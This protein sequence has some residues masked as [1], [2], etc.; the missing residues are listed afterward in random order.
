MVTSSSALSDTGH[1][2]DLDLKVSPAS[3]FSGY[4]T[5][6]FLIRLQLAEDQILIERRQRL[7]LENE[8]SIGKQNILQ[9][10]AKFETLQNSFFQEIQL[11]KNETS[12]DAIE[13]TISKAHSQRKNTQLNDHFAELDSRQRYLE[14][15]RKN[16]ENELIRLTSEISQINTRLESLSTD[17]LNQKAQSILNNSRIQNLRPFT[18]EILEKFTHTINTI[19]DLNKKE[20]LE[21][22]NR[23]IQKMDGITMDMRKFM[24]RESRARTMLE[25]RIED[26]RQE[27][28]TL[29]TTSPKTLTDR[30]DDIQNQINS[31]SNRESENHHQIVESCQASYKKVSTDFGEIAKILSERLDANELSDEEEKLTRQRFER[32]VS[33]HMKELQ[34]AIQANLDTIVT[35]LS[36]GLQKSQ[37]G[38]FRVEKKVKVEVN[39]MKEIF[40]VEEKAKDKLKQDLEE[41]RLLVSQI[42]NGAEVKLESFQ[43]ELKSELLDVFKEVSFLKNSAHL[44]PGEE[45]LSHHQVRKCFQFF[46]TLVIVLIGSSIATYTFRTFPPLSFT[47]SP[48]CMKT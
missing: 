46:L 18:N 33:I 19:H 21:N 28:H 9:L 5:N 7:L 35:Q 10:S 3:N 29:L 48:F 40:N 34:D 24:E 14:Q 23:A 20:C 39:S 42:K 44:K 17:V 22:T 16:D 6:D 36:H 37:E 38:I 2:L 4:N 27:M 31:L 32:Q 43:H 8:V 12:S 1:H 45:N 15:S 41:I 11:R 25:Q 30:F 47:S 26:L 13:M